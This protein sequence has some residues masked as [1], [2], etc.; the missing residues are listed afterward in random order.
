[1]LSKQE[2][3]QKE[4]QKY[5]NIK[6]SLAFGAQGALKAAQKKHIIILVDTLR[7]STT[8]TTALDNGAKKI[9]PITTVEEAKKLAQQIGKDTI[10]AGERYG[11]K[12]KG[13]QLGN[14]PLEYTSQRVEGKIIILTTTNLTQ[15]ANS[16]KNTPHLF[17][18]CLINAK[19]VAQ[20]AKKTAQKTGNPITII[21]VG[22]LK[23]KAP[24]DYITA[25]TIKNYIQN[26][27]LPQNIP[28]KILKTPN[29]KYLIQIGYQKDV[30]YCSQLNTTTTVPIY[31]NK[32]FKK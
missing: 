14:S 8:I 4:K 2:K 22:R 17:I 31:E 11:I 21:H 19:S 5:K 9:I 3:E 26:K 25:Q 13:F 24:E 12:V 20:K 27:T 32:A 1:M 6:V 16:A 30:Q 18:G 23:Q 15:V 29:A 28:Q 10:L 7:A